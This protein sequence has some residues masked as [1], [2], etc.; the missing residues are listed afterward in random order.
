[1]SE[2]DPHPATTQSHRYSA[3]HGRPFRLLLA[4]SSVSLLGTRISTIAF[5]M[6]VLWITHSPV[7]AGWTAF[8]ATAPSVLVYVPA[9]ALVDVWPPR[10]V[11]L[12]SEFGRGLALLTVVIALLLGKAFL[13]LLIGAAVIEEILEVFSTLAER[14]YVGSLVQHDQASSALVRMEART[15]VMVLAGRPLGGILFAA[16]PLFPF[17]ADM[18]SFIVSVGTLIAI[19]G[20]QAVKF[21]TSFPG[22]TFLRRNL[23]PS[24]GRTGEEVIDQTRPKASWDGLWKDIARGIEWL[25]SDRFTCVSILLSAG[26]TLICQAL[27]MIFLAYASDRHLPSFMIGIALAASGFG[28]TAGS[29]L[30]ARLPAPTRYNWTL[31]RI[32]AWAISI[33][34]LVAP[35]ELQFMPSGDFLFLR[36]A[37][38]MSL[39][40][41]TGALGNV[42]L[43]TYLIQNAPV[44]ML[45]RVTSIG[46]LMSFGACAVGPVLGGLIIQRYK[47]LGAVLVLSAAIM[48]IS[49][50]SLLLP[51]AQTN[52][53]RISKFAALALK[54]AKSAMTGVGP[55]FKISSLPGPTLMA[56]VGDGLSESAKQSVTCS[57]GALAASVWDPARQADATTAPDTGDELVAANHAPSQRDITGLSAAGENAETPRT[58]RRPKRFRKG[59]CAAGAVRPVGD[60]D[61][62][63]KTRHSHA[64]GAAPAGDFASSQR[65]GQET[66][67]SSADDHQHADWPAE[68][69]TADYTAAAAPVSDLEPAGSRAAPAMQPA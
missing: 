57:S 65:L 58:A 68:G 48:I 24:T 32:I 2:P 56:Q 17:I 60:D 16:G 66:P 9:G 8:A 29:A 30:A 41:F 19:K 53:S 69:H 31:T 64:I 4:G 54:T 3:V 11:M 47:I 38:V 25:R 52:K 62:A 44:E 10:R 21:F 36:F 33:G 15:H 42:E 34:V 6:L 49:V 39:L 63:L 35:Y 20:E 1:M 45:A 40:G 27:I 43:G 59:R 23:P 55:G 7:A 61:S 46:R 26:T 50:L 18:I 67:G 12:I 14:R 5:P 51:S 37:I 13:P 22:T 28:G